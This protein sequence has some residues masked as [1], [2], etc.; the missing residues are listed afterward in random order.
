MCTG[1]R[2]E[3]STP[4]LSAPACPNSQVLA[5][6]AARPRSSPD[7][8]LALRAA[9]GMGKTWRYS[10]SDERGADESDGFLRMPEH[11]LGFEPDPGNRDA[12]A[13]DP[14]A[15]PLCRAVRGT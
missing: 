11:E 7:A 1:N 6:R 3:G 12:G 13:P 9:R 4:S 14:G 15:R 10:R 5:L 2:T 8:V